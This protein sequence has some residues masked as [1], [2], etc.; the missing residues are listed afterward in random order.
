MSLIDFLKGLT[1]H[2]FADMAIDLGTANTLVALPG[3]GVVVNEP[4]VVAIERATQRVIAVG[5]EAKSMINRTPDEYQAVRPLRDGVVA[6]YDITEG[7]I[8]AFI[9]RVAPREHVW[10][11]RPRVVICIPCGATMVERRAAFES[12]IQA[13][14]CEAFLL[15][16]PMAAALGAGLPVA[17]PTAT[18]VVDI[19]GGTTE[20]AVMSLGGIVASTSLRLAGNRMDEAISYHLRDQ[21]GISVGERTAEVIKMKIG[22]AM[23]FEDGRE[24]DMIISGQDILSGQPKEVTIK[25]EDV[26]QALAPSCEEMVRRVQETFR[27][28]S[29]EVASDIIKNGILLTG[30]GGMLAGLDR[31]LSSHLEIPVKTSETALTNVVLGCLKALET[32]EVLGNALKRTGAK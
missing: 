10:D 2:R 12:V 29:P 6:D 16:E 31:Y 28:T 18:M 8:A 3:K 5:Q 19:G 15:E 30:G 9:N 4:S 20:I 24:R 17:E 27:K 7:M 32:P 1:G 14:A 26:R 25:S 23:P 21:L 11:A 13:G 22:S